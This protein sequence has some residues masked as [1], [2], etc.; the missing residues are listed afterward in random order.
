MCYRTSTVWFTDE[1]F[2]AITTAA[3]VT[4]NISDSML[5]CSNAGHPPVLVRMS[6][7][8][9]LPLA[10]ET[11]SDKSNLPLGVFS[12]PFTTIEAKFASTQETGSSSIP[13]AFRRRLTRN[14][15]KS[16]EKGKCPPC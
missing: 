16:S 11:Q 3:V 14:P 13:M 8:R 12:P 5:Y 4:Y 6:G 7:G 15:M 2:A 10:L 9:W 1:V